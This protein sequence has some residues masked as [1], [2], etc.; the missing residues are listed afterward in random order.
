MLGQ[1]TLMAM[2]FGANQEEISGSS[3]HRDIREKHPETSWPMSKRR[4]KPAGPIRNDLA[5]HK[6]P[7]V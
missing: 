3:Q 4:V 7:P 1:N 6:V 5:R 2:H